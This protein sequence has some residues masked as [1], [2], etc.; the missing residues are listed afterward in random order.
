L[1]ESPER[2]NYI[3]ADMLHAWTLQA[4]EMPE[5]RQVLVETMPTFEDW[6]ATKD[7]PVEV[8]LQP[9]NLHSMARLIRRLVLEAND[10]YSGA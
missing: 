7:R 8:L 1:L 5:A 9:Y 6:Q 10:I 3:S 4:I 2:R